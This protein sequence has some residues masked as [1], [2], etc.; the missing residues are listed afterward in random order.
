ME[1]CHMNFSQM[2]MAINAFRICTDV[3][4]NWSDEQIEEYHQLVEFY[5]N[6]VQLLDIKVE[7][8]RDNDF[9]PEQMRDFEREVRIC[10]LQLQFFFATFVSLTLPRNLTL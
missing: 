10:Q 9:T 6:F 4:K 5:D 1:Q 8:L 2:E 3:K 7:Y